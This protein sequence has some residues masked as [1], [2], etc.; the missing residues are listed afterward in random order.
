[1]K[2]FKRVTS[3]LSIFLLMVAIL[4]NGTSLNPLKSRLVYADTKSTSL[5]VIGDSISYGMSADPG[6]GFADLYTKHLNETEGYGNVKL[7][8][9]S[10]PGDKTADLLMK[11]STQPFTDAL[12]NGDIVVVS[13]GGNNLLSPI[14]AAICKAFNVNASGN[15]NLLADLTNAIKNDPNATATLAKL[16]STESLFALSNDL[17][18]GVTN[19]GTEFPKIATEIKRQAPNAQI[20]MLTLYNPFDAKDQLNPIFNQ[21]ISGINKVV[22]EQEK[23]IGYTMVDVNK[24]FSSSSDAVKFNL[25]GSQIDPHPTNVGH[26]IINKQIISVEKPLNKTTTG[27]NSEASGQNGTG[28][29]TNSG[30]STGQDSAA[31]PDLNVAAI[32][33]QKK[34]ITETMSAAKKERASA[35]ISLKKVQNEVTKS[36]KDYKILKTKAAKLKTK[37]EMNA[38][39]M[40]LIATDTKKKS[41]EAY[42][43]YYKAMI[44]KDDITIKTAQKL[45]ELKTPS[46]EEI[47]L[48]QE[49]LSKQHADADRVV[50]TKKVVA[51]KAAN[52]AKKAAESAAKAKK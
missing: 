40:L 38:S 32:D 15:N 1:M 10:M 11:L 43:S 24:A 25:S 23:V 3:L 52:V 12:S 19:F 8:N 51:E 45:L 9:L 29:T 48:A 6:K 4:L 27:G 34:V 47:N 37:T 42:V 49:E 26:E 20:Y 14:I 30:I 5:V 13:I 50:A 16:Q 33:Q 28:T 39:K 44:N 17:Y 36:I 46:I 21:F 41:A 2:N 22:S 35:Q 7:T 31:T 18:P